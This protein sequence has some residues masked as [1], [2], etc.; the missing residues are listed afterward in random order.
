MWYDII[1]RIKEKIDYNMDL[2]NNA[3]S[4]FLVILS[5]DYGCEISPE[6]DR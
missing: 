4:V 5:F 2:D 3:H 6:S 1:N